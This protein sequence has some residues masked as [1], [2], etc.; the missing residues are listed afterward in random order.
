MGSRSRGL[1]PG[2]SGAVA[3]ADCEAYCSAFKVP[4]DKSYLGED[5]VPHDKCACDGT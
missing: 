3:K 2:T 4:A 1:D 5:V